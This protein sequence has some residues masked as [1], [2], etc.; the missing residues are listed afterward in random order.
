MS[1]PSYDDTYLIGK[2]LKCAVAADKVCFAPEMRHG[3]LSACL[4]VLDG[5]PP[6]VASTPAN[7]ARVATKTPG[8]GVMAA[9]ISDAARHAHRVAWPYVPVLWVQEHCCHP[10]HCHH[11]RVLWHNRP[12]PTARSPSFDCAFL[13]QRAVVELLGCTSSSI[14]EKKTAGCACFKG[15]GACGTG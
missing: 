5:D 4:V 10:R 6:C 3:R 8:M 13:W 12:C 9:C 7:E 15:T 11:H 1:L 14:D 2:L